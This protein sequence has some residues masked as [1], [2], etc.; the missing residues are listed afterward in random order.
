MQFAKTVKLRTDNGEF[1]DIKLSDLRCDDDGQPINAEQEQ[2]LAKLFSGHNFRDLSEDERSKIKAVRARV[3]NAS[4]PELADAII[5]R[6]DLS[7]VSI[8]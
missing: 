8:N 6:F 5:A 7:W 2:V 3:S 1:K 4:V